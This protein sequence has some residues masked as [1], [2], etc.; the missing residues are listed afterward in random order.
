MSY[1]IITLIRNKQTRRFIVEGQIIE[2]T[3]NIAPAI[4]LVFIAIPSLRLLYL[5]DEVHNPTL[6]LKGVGHQ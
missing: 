5:I 6:T 4:I 1:I 3:R 2:T